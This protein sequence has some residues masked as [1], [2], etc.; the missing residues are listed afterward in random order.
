[1][2][3]HESNS[4]S[5]SARI[6]YQ[7][8]WA[9]T[10]TVTS[11]ASRRTRN[12]LETPGWLIRSRSVN[13]PTSRG[14]SRSRSSIIR[15]VGSASAS[16]MVTIALIYHISYITVKLCNHLFWVMC[17]AESHAI[18]AILSRGFGTVSG[19]S[20]CDKTTCFGTRI[21]TKLALVRGRQLAYT[22]TPHCYERRPVC[23][24]LHWRC[25]CWLRWRAMR[26]RLLEEARPLP[27]TSRRLTCLP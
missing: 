8:R 22:E 15:R 14:R 11:P 16:N 3:S 7:W 1:M 23:R 18:S 17:G 27:V 24:E 9:S 26:L 4:A 13:S 2:P 21:V 12:C 20:E 25:W 10:R 6:S 19:H 5:G